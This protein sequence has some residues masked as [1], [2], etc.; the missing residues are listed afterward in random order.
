M[1]FK[2]SLLERLSL[3]IGVVA[4]LGTTAAILVGLEFE[5][6]A[7]YKSEDTSSLAPIDEGASQKKKQPA[8]SSQ[9]GTP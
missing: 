3:P 6:A 9:P 5:N 2:R 7:R 1:T 8:I 4:I